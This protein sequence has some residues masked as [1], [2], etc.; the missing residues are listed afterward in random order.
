[1]KPPTQLPLR[2]QRYHLPNHER[3]KLA[4]WVGDDAN[5]AGIYSRP[6]IA[7]K[8]MAALGIGRIP[9]SAIDVAFK[10]A[11]KPLPRRPKPVKPPKPEVP[12]EPKSSGR[13][14]AEQLLRACTQLKVPLND[15]FL[16]LLDLKKGDKA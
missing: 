7:K 4:L 6:E 11:G 1:M 12:A 8:A 15:E 2:Q 14:I 3:M 10:D 13:I 5:V 9:D 16:A